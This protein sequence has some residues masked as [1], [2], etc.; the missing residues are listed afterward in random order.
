MYLNAPS[1]DYG[2]EFSIVEI[3]RGAHLAFEGASMTSTQVVGDDT[4]AIS[5]APGQLLKIET[6]SNKCNYNNK[7]SDLSMNDQMQLP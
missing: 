4:G 6:V 2:F 7:Q 5:V 3:Y 1:E